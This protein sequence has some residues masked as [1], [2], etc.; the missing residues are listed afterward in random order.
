MKIEI[1]NLYK[2]FEDKKVFEN[3]NLTLEK[4]M[5]VILGKSGGGKSTLL[6]IIS[7]LM[8]KDFGEIKGV[9]TDEISYIFQEDR[10]ISWL[11]VKEN[12]E[13]FIYEY[14]SKE[15]GVKKI[16]EVLKSFN[17]EET[18]NKYPENLS[19][20]MR[21]RVNIARALLKPSKLI[22]MDEPFKSLDYKIKYIIMEE[23]KKFFKRENSMVIFVT[24]DID[25]AI[26]M[27]EEI[28]VLG[29]TPFKIKGIY[30]ENLV[31]KK[32]KILNLI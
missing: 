5:N 14:Y 16:K 6:N 31:E 25:E 19:G 2:S 17:I 10:L 4:N 11:T 7:G 32:D 18:E 23:L 24:H 26:F 3:F 12:M 9:K 15:E 20:G 13:L 29:D 22:L 21:Q 28:I 8:T 27:G 1:K 30:N